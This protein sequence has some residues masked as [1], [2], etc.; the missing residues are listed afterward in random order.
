M[1]R[2]PI[3]ALLLVVTT[4]TTSLTLGDESNLSKELTGLQ[5][6]IGK[7]FRGEFAKSTPEK[8]IVDVSSWERILN[9]KG[10]RMLHSINNGEYGGETI[11]MWD[12]QQKKV[13]Y[14]YFTTAGFT[15]KGTVEFNKN[16]WT[17]LEE[18]SGSASG[19]TKVRATSTLG[20]DGSLHVKSEYLTN[21]KWTPGHEVTYKPN[22]DAKVTFK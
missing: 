5:P 7:T 19:V 9:G 21:D 2:W 14:W 18:V 8:P 22:R 15:T 4:A 6:L 11:F 17:T 12:D 3:I 16:Q 10:V 20:D 13:A 1:F